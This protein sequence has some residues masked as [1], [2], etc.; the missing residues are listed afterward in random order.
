MNNNEEEWRRMK[1]NEEE[2]RR[3]KDIH[4]F[5]QFIN[6]LCSKIKE[7]KYQINLKSYLV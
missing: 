5:L 4:D 3:M 6:Q 1:N 7:I 2:W